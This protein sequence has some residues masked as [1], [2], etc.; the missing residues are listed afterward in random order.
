MKEIK[1]IALIGFGLEAKSAYEFLKNQHPNAIF[2]IYDQNQTSK[3]T[4]PDGVNFY[5]GMSDFSQIEA[6]LIVRTPAVRPD[7]LPANIE[8]T[9]VTNLF[10]EHCPA[11]IIGVTGT[12]GKGTTS[13]LIASILRAR[14][15]KTHLVGNIGVP[16]LDILP[17]ISA[18]DAVVFETSSFQ[19]WD[20]KKSPAISVVLMIEPDHLDV[21]ADFEEYL[22]AK[23]QIRAHQTLSDFCI[24][25]AENEFSRKIV[26]DSGAK[27]SENTLCYGADSANNCFVQGDKFFV[28]NGEVLREICSTSSVKLPGAHSLQNA[29]AAI[30]AALSF[31]S[32]ISNEEISAGLGGFTGLP[33]RLKFVREIDGVDF[34]DDSI[35]TTPGSAIAAIRAFERP[36]VL[37]L[38]G[39]DKGADLAPLFDEIL[40][41][42]SI[43]KVLIYGA[44]SPK[45]A[46]E[47]VRRGFSNF[48]SLDQKP[49]F[50]KVVQRA[51]EVAQSGDV[52]VLSPA[53][54]S[55]DM[56]ASY[57]DRGEQFVEAVGNLQ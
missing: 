12:K 56:F 23:S 38:G 50:K 13:S 34:Y 55:F 41:S 54:A 40:A 9:S 47:F 2:D 17:E 8:V 31:D 26:L 36:K 57:A 20:L 15:H 45:L 11:K 24:F 16:A 6:D 53:H 32:E 28:R 49:L 33:H 27:N 51:H 42:K 1:K 43:R 7:R 5:G 4:L 39:S 21:H 22:T 14:G 3:V 46:E 29:C 35:S 37:L 52:V 19:L 10:F 30:L 48:E 44:Q 18:G 25:N